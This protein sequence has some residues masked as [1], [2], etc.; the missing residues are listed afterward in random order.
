MRIIMIYTT[1]HIAQQDFVS[2]PK[3]WDYR[4]RVS[5]KEVI[6]AASKRG[7]LNYKFL[8]SPCMVSF[9]ND[10]LFTSLAQ[11]LAAYQYRK[12]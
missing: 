11:I 4:D 9:F 6:K 3:Q 7:P 10:N 2:R 5:E 12:L 1:L 8:F